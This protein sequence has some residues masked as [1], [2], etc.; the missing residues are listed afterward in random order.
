[1]GVGKS[2]LATI[3]KRYGV[4]YKAIFEIKTII[5]DTRSN[6]PGGFMCGI[7]LW[8]IGVLPALMNSAER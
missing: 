6:V 7:K 1:M 4:A 2:A 8:E 5:E 3:N